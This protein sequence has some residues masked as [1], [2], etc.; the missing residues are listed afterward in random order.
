MHARIVTVQFQ[1]GKVDEGTQIYRESILP[2]MRQQA[3]FQG[4]M[5][6]LDRSTDKGISITLWQTEANA[7]AS[8]SGS[9]FFQAQIAKVA[10][11]SAAAPIVETYEVAVQE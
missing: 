10:S 9:A 7:Q 4:V 5:A 8:G 1:P 2:E 3:G 11:L 6:L